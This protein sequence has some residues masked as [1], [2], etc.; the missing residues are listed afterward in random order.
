MPDEEI[1]SPEALFRG[2]PQSLAIHRRVE[3]VVASIGPA[4]V[5]VSRSQAAFRR[6]TGFAFV[7]RPGQYVGSDVPA[8]LSIALGREVACDRFKEV[9]HP[10]PHVWMH[11]LELHTVD[12]VDDEVRSWLVEAYARAG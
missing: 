11:H 8:V 2:F 4:S 12:E 1:A 9:A 10:S 5:R 7:W 3:Q 6:R